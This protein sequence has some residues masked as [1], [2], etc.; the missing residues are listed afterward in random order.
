MKEQN[1]EIYDFIKNKKFIYCVI[2]VL[3]LFLYYEVRKDE[4]HLEKI[5]ENNII[6]KN[7]QVQ[8]EDDINLTNSKY[9]NMKIDKENIKKLILEEKEKEEQD[10]QKKQEEDKIELWKIE[11]FFATLFCVIYG[12]LYYYAYYYAYNG[13]KKNKPVNEEK[14]YLIDDYTKY[15][16]D[17][18][19]IEYLINKEEK[20][21]YNYL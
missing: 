20:S 21:E 18:T 5:K 1:I 4:E 9:L 8:K 17:E 6:N 13:E 12:G 2:V 19:E 15:L 10:I 16:L 11:T 3:S 14:T 7:K